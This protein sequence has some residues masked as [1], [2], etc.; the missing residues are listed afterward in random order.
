ML[1][2]VDIV[3]RG[4][5]I[6]RIVK[7]GREK[8]PSGAA[9]VDLSGGYAIPG[10]IDGHVHL[11][12]RPERGLELMLRAG[13]VAVRD[14]GGDG[15]Y[16]RQIKAAIGKGEILG[17]DIYF[18]ALVGGPDLILNDDRAKM[19]TPMDYE[20][21]AAPWMRIVDDSSNIAQVVADAVT[22]GATG[23]KIYSHVSSDVVGRI[24]L[25]AHR[26]G[27]KVWAHSFVYPARPEDVVAAGTDVI[28]HAEGLLYRPDW[29]PGRGPGLDTSEVK[30][31]RLAHI[32][33]AMQARG[34]MLDPTVLVT[35]DR[36]ARNDNEV[37]SS[38]RAALYEV[39]RLAHARGIALVAGTD[40][41]P[42]TSDE[43]TPALYE[44]LRVLV[45]K[46][47]L[48]PGEAITA[49]TRNNAVA[50]GIEGSYGTIEPGKV[51]DIII[52]EKD[53]TADIRSI[54]KIKLVI[55]NGLPLAPQS[56]GEP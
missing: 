2:G 25:E 29:A 53:P 13:I 6:Q 10:L 26:R 5:L 28:S 20:L 54:S 56:K 38:K 43:E 36:L 33:D 55:K 35:N 21:G 19:A 32:L 46:A 45:D 9:L 8:Y 47:G 24:C 52:L 3:I 48:T 18:S 51:A 34:T 11:T 22:C 30:S 1:P 31:E 41:P 44:E 40:L 49:A 39:V 42:P 50:L 23:I 7:H 12:N 16:L 15:A 4:Q 27:I 17:P 14:M 37:N